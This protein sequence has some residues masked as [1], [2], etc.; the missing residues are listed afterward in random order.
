MKR[1]F[2]FFYLVPIWVQAQQTVSMTKL[3][4]MDSVVMYNI[5]DSI[6]F[7]YAKNF[8]KDKQLFINGL[9]VDTI[10]FKL[11]GNPF[12][13]QGKIYF[14]AKCSNDIKKML[15]SIQDRVIT[16]FDYQFVYG[17][18]QMI[19]YIEDWLFGKIYTFDVETGSQKVLVDFWDI[20]EKSVWGDGKER[21]DENFE[22]IFFLNKD[23]VYVTLCYDDGS[24]GDHY[25]TKIRHFI[26][27]KNNR[28]DIT[29]KITPIHRLGIG[30]ILENYKSEMQ[31]ASTDGKYI[32]ETCYVDMYNSEIKKSFRKNISRIFDDQFNYIDEILPMF[33]IEINGVN[34]QKNVL[35][36]YFLETSIDAKDSTVKVIGGYADKRVIIPYVFDPVLEIAMYKAY[37]NSLLAQNDI[38]DFGKYELG[39]LRNLIFAKYNYVFSS[40]FYQAYFNLYEF[41][42]NKDARKSRV[43]NV[44]D[45]LTETDKAN[46][47]LI[48]DAENKLIKK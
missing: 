48:Q 47:K 32:K 4:V 15:Y 36:N 23:N 26:A 1:L 30:E 7:T 14:N 10:G 22:Q 19:S 35:R 3:I 18:A 45:K 24:Y 41:Y 21:S 28:M 43:K 34:I 42:G 31:L 33:N 37:E 29:K 38:K 39:I 2:L 44:N 9:P 5:I 16:A 13:Y 20:V 6:E 40:E 25:C 11:M 27:G 8:N 46:I 17:D 12:V